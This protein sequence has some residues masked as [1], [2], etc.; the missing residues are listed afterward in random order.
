MSG[1]RRADRSAGRY[2]RATCSFVRSAPASV[3]SSRGS[4]P[5][6]FLHLCKRESRAD[7]DYI[8]DGMRWIGRQAQ[9]VKLLPGSNAHVGRIEVGALFGQLPASLLGTLRCFMR[10]ALVGSPGQIASVGQR[11]M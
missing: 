8:E 10:E 6:L 1:S 9:L 4:R 11:H 7:G 3:R 2:Q 5:L